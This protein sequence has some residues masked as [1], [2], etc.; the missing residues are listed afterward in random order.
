MYK[1]SVVIS[2]YN[3]EAVLNKF[4]NAFDNIIPKIK[5]DYELIFVDDGSKDQ[6]LPILS[7][8]V[9]R[10]L[11]AKIVSFSR[12]FGHEAAMIAGIDCATGDGIIC[13]DADL[14][15]PLECIPE[16]ISKLEDGYEVIN[17]IRLSNKSAGFVKNLSSHAFYKVVNILSSQASFEENAS[18]FF[19][20]S[21]RV[22]DILRNNYREKNRFLRGY[23][24]SVGFKKTNLTYNAAER[25][26]GSS[27]YSLRKL[28]RF[29]I[30][31][32]ILYSDFPL[33]LGV[34]AGVISATLGIIA[35]IYTWCTYSNAPS[36]YATIV[37]LICFLFSVL[38]VIIGIIGEY[39][40]VL[41]SELKDRPIYIVEKRVNFEHRFHDTPKNER[42]VSGI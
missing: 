37:T 1:L 34:Y 11:K 38:F 31:T 17:M 22:G 20:I 24:Q 5:W 10:N 36:G 3:E 12:N 27:H 42:I 23:V 35:L 41:F 26:G 33:K 8:Y 32:I 28:F 29:S 39:I 18:D 7:T 16:I 4:F 40:A 25:A 13:M 14:Q 15:H 6:S 9:N 30:S 19:A 2:V 21:K